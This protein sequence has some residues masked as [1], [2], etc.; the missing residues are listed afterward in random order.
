MQRLGGVRWLGPPSQGPKADGAGDPAA[1]DA[2]EEERPAELLQEWTVPKSIVI[3]V[4]RAKDLRDMSSLGRMDPYAEVIY[5]VHS[6][7]EL[8][9]QTRVRKHGGR[10]PRWRDQFTIPLRKNKAEVEVNV[11]DSD[12]VGRDNFIGRTLVQLEPIFRTAGQVS[13]E[14]H[15]LHERHGTAHNHGSILLKIECDDKVRTGCAA[16]V[17]M[18]CRW[19]ANLG[20][21]MWDSL[22]DNHPWISCIFVDPDDTFTRPQRTTVLMTVIFG[23]LCIAAILEDVPQCLPSDLGYPDCVGFQEELALIEA[24]GT[25]LDDE[26]DTNWKQFFTTIVIISVCMLPCDRVFVTMFEKMEG[27]RQSSHGRGPAGRMWDLP[28]VP[29]TDNNIVARAQASIRGF[30]AR[31][32]HRLEAQARNM[33]KTEAWTAGSVARPGSL[34]FLAP[35]AAGDATRIRHRLYPRHAQR[36]PSA[37]ASG[38][39][40]SGAEDGEQAEQAGRTGV[41]S[42]ASRLPA[43]IRDVETVELEMTGPHTPFGKALRQLDSSSSG[44]DGAPAAPSGPTQRELFGSPV[45][46]GGKSDELFLADF[47]PTARPPPSATPSAPTVPPPRAGSFF[48]RRAFPTAGGRAAAANPRPPVLTQYD[49]TLRYILTDLET[50]LLIRVQACGRGMAL[51]ARL[52]RGWRAEW[53]AITHEKL[54]RLWRKLHIVA[55]V[56]GTVQMK[57][58]RYV[59]RQRRLAKKA[60]KQQKAEDEDG[61]E[62]PAWYAYVAWTSAVV[63]CV[64]CGLYTMVLA[65]VWGPV[66]TLD[67]LFMSFG[68]LGYGG[69]V[70]D[71]FKIWVMVVAGDQMEFLVDLYMEFMDFMPFQI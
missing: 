61:V 66:T 33:I 31:R 54:A 23:N 68:A 45:A 55:L 7:H 67:W 56:V 38:A 51:R 16:K 71:V 32:K 64:L 13:E 59:R 5:G 35:P 57:R 11:F 58:K 42:L 39:E 20:P 26:D 48:R 46:K 36:T 12:R 52:R 40:A 37:E 53:Q 17:R 49:P 6:R 70:Q 41:S 24:N 19:F 3:T 43:H 4:E 62:L 50:A 63:W 2:E 1:A 29:S 14:W 27:T 21:K 44:A 69:A 30:L 25:A 28:E 22:K 18:F 8:R 65:L 60:A 10:T 47:A 34:G 9:K 15:T